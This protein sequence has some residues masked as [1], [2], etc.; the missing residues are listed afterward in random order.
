MKGTNMLKLTLTWGTVAALGALVY[1][2]PSPEAKPDECSAGRVVSAAQFAVEASLRD[3]ATA[4]F[5][6]MSYDEGLVFGK[7][8]AQNVF[9]AYV[10]NRFV[11]AVDCVN[12]AAVVREVTI[13]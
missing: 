8:R 13:R 1:A 10:V 3:P 6:E 11:A 2:M 5:S 9:G 7:V 12:N 4:S